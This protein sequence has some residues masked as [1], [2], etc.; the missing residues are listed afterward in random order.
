MEHY[1]TVEHMVAMRTKLSYE[2]GTNVHFYYY[3]GLEFSQS[4]LLQVI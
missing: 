2:N 1:C 4:D 3:T